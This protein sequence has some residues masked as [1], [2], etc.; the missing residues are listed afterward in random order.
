M[1]LRIVF[2]VVATVA[3]LAVAGV[4]LAQ[5]KALIEKGLKL[6]A[7]QKCSMCHSIAG[8][9]NVKGPLDAVGT[10]L[11]SDELMAWLVKPAEM[12]VKMKA[13]RKPPMKAYATLPKEDLDAL[14]AYMMSLKK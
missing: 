14:V 10:K 1:K 5:D 12:H 11:K 7:D 8:K 2:T 9:G 3:A 4:A 6:Y 13:D